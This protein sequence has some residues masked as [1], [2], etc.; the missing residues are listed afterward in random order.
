MSP[1]NFAS[2]FVE[3]SDELARERVKAAV[4]KVC[5]GQLSPDTDFTS[6]WIKLFGDCMM[7]DRPNSRPPKIR[8][9]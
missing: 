6:Q 8:N 4:Q 1:G 9:D 2:Q 5:D 3:I 7:K